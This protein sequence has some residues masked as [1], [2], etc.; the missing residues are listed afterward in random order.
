MVDAVEWGGTLGRVHQAEG[1]AL[2]E[3]WRGHFLKLT[4]AAA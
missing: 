1:D 3:R 4:R 2:G